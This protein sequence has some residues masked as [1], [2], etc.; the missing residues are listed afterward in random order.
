MPRRIIANNNVLKAQKSNSLMISKVFMDSL[1]P[2]FIVLCTSQA[3]TDAMRMLL[4]HCW[5]LVTFLFG[6]WCGQHFDLFVAIE[7]AN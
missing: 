4:C 7:N 3:K 6:F 1:I 5:S 2:F